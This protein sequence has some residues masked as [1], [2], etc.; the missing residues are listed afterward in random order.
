MRDVPRKLPPQKGQIN[1]AIT[2]DQENR[3]FTIHT[4]NSTYQMKVDQYGF[5]LHLYY[6]R[7]TEGNM[8]YLLTY[9]DRGFSGNPYD[10]GMNRSYSLDALP[11]E[12]PVRGSGDYRSP[13]FDVRNADGSFGCDLRFKGYKIIS[14]KYGLPGLPAVYAEEKE[15]ETL[16]MILEDTTSDLEVALLYGVL[17]ELDIITRCVRITNQMEQEVILEKVQSACLDFTGG[18]FDLLTFY[19]RHMMERNVQRAAVGHGSFQIGSRRGTSS[20]QYNPM[21]ILSDQDTTENS[22]SCYAMSFVYSGGFLGEVEKDQYDQTRMQLG[23][24]ED[25]F[26]YPLMPGETFFAPEVIMTYSGEG[27][28]QLSRNLH[29]CIRKHI[30]RGKY[31]DKVRPVLANSWEAAY[32]NFNGDT[33]YNLA[34]EAAALGMEMLVLD[35]GWFG[36]R[37]DDN[38]SLGDWQVNET[39]L[40][41]SLK[42]LTNAVNGLGLKFGIWIEPEMV[43]ED[44]ELYRKHPDWVL[45]L[46]GKKP[47][48]ARNQLVLDFSR[49]EVADSIFKQ[50]CDVLD[51]GNIEYIK[52][53][54][55]RSISDVYSH[56]TL[57]GKVL[58]DYVLGLYDFLERL[59]ERYPDILIEGCSGG[60]G[61]FDAGMLYYTPQI[62]CSDNTDAIDR[63][64][65][66]YGT[67]F[68][69]PASTV[70]AHV[71]AAPNHQTGRNIPLKTRGIM[72]MSG[73]FGYELDLCRLSQE[74]KEEIK[75]QIKTFHKYAALIQSG[76]MYRLGNPGQEEVA[77]WAFVSEDKSE[78]LLNLF[79]LQTHGNMPV[80]Y[81][82]LSGLEEGRMYKEESSGKVYPANALMEAG[83]PILAPMGDFQAEQMYFRRVEES[84]GS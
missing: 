7:K 77:A 53:D 79:I 78:V 66:Q 64:R 30:C 71:S 76:D 52:W 60:G 19:G 21:M 80:S 37:N 59:I 43:S 75:E 9:M 14:G 51:Q 74:E 12:Y 6:G 5:L 38:T 50:I 13:A 41:C 35:D 34:K 49:K 40:G 73:T 45:A 84:A 1:M 27:I 24:M 26:S 25:Q 63:S 20:H 18:S 23:L 82:R 44:S 67:S 69:Y 56:T 3:I 32:M 11:Q 81:I 58:Y 16:E 31:K 72:A 33:I 4:K 15:A 8:D 2:A 62:W 65:I 29:K 28:G 48:R 42:E 70:G 22:G 55:N 54:Y 68:G 10:A 39:K 36:Q 17:P 57:P 61:R 47:V 46:P 83:I